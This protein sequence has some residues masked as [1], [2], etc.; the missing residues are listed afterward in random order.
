MLHLR[1]LTLSLPPVVQEENLDIKAEWFHKSYEYH[2]SQET[3]ELCNQEFARVMFD[4]L[5][6]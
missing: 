5:S 6:K 2:L 1:M 4:A 3:L